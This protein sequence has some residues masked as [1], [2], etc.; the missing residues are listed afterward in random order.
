MRRRRGAGPPR[1]AS[2]RSLC[3]EMPADAASVITAK[4]FCP[5]WNARCSATFTESSI[6]PMAPAPPW[7]GAAPRPARRDSVRTSPVFGSR[8]HLWVRP[9]ISATAL[10]PPSRSIS[11]SSGFGGNCRAL[12][13]TLA[14]ATAC[15]AQSIFLPAE[16]VVGKKL[17]RSWSTINSGPDAK[18]SRH[19]S[20]VAVLS[21]PRALLMTDSFVVQSEKTTASPFSAASKA[22]SMARGTL[23]ATMSPLKKRCCA[24]QNWLSAVLACVSLRT[25]CSCKRS[26]MLRRSCHSFTAESYWDR[27][28]SVSGVVTRSKVVPA[29]ASERQESEPVRRSCTATS[30]IAATPPFS[31][32]FRKA[33]KLGKGQ[34][35]R[36]P[37]LSGSSSAEPAPHSPSRTIYCMCPTSVAPV[38]VA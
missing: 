26:R 2:R 28:T 12:S 17:L 6:T 32:T 11:S 13:R 33:A 5:H 24:D 14:A 37:S 4:S 30:S 3:K 19:W 21:A 23:A 31:T 27:A 36:R 38:A 22:I 7:D 29:K 10:G 25:S 1:R 16:S 9:D 15:A 20:A 18:P 8:Q 35:A 34:G